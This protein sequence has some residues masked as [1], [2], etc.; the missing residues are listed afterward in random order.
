[1]PDIP[2]CIAMLA[3]HVNAMRIMYGDFREREERRLT[4][5]SRLTQP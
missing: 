3:V 2:V 4:V 1:M 5:I